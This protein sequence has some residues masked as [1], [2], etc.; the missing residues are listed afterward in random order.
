[1][2]PLYLVLTGLLLLNGPAFSQ[3]ADTTQ[4]KAFMEG[5]VTTHLRDKHIAGATVSVIRDG[6]ILLAKG[7][8]FADVDKQIPVSAS[9]T[10]FRQRLQ[11]LLRQSRGD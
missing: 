4:L 9:S 5:V 7:Y 2:K 10:L 6:K 1:M 3:P 11:P 8:G